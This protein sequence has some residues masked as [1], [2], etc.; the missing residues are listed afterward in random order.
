MRAPV[1]I[2]SQEP[3]GAE[4]ELRF[5][6]ADGK[7]LGEAI[8]NVTAKNPG[9]DLPVTGSCWQKPTLRGLPGCLE[10]DPLTSH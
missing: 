8:T 3:R 5:R 10:W 1:C 7:C 2:H 9:R 6:A 4:G